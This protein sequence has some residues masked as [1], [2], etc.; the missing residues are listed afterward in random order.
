MKITIT[1]S[2]GHISKPLTQESVQTGHSIAVIS[3][4]TERKKDIEALGASL[5]TGGACH[6][7]DSFTV[8]RLTHFHLL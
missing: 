3:S 6:Q 5:P 8:L 1:G 4:R 7:N 2:L